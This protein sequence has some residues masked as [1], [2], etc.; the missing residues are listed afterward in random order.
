M[1]KIRVKEKDSETEKIEN[2][3][4]DLMSIGMASLGTI[5]A[6]TF[7]SMADLEY[8]KIGESWGA[9]FNK[10]RKR[11]RNGCYI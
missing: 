5:T 1:R 4:F 9:D 11:D 10:D 7:T 3:P 8:Y 2:T 6:N